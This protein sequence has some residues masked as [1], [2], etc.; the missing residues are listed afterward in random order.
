M[1]RR[2]GRNQHGNGGSIALIWTN[3]KIE[4]VHTV[5]KMKHHEMEKLMVQIAQLIIF[6]LSPFVN[7]F[8]FSLPSSFKGSTESIYL[9]MWRSKV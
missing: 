7:E 3:P 6:T 1:G 2:F 9:I 4:E 5:L 8:C